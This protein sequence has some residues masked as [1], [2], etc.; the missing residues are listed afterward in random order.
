MVIKFFHRWKEQTPQLKDMGSVN[1]CR[2]DYVWLANSCWV[3]YVVT[4]K[5]KKMEFL[6]L[7]H[8]NPSTIRQP[9]LV[10]ES[11]QTQGYAIQ[12]TTTKSLKQFNVKMWFNNRGWFSL[13]AH[14]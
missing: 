2:I 13:F 9:I 14:Q 7:H 12:H 11:H 8:G 10:I 4:N 1:W 3:S 5:G 6:P